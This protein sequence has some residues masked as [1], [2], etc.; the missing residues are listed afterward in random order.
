MKKLI[1]LFAIIFSSTL[2]AQTANLKT[3]RNA[4]KY[5]TE[6]TENFPNFTYQSPDNEN[7][8][9]IRETFNLDSITGNGDEMSK[10]LNLMHWVHNSVRHNGNNSANCE[11]DAID[12]YNYY[13][14]TGKGINCRNLATMLNECYLAMGIPS[15][16]IT[17][18]PKDSTDRDCH[19][20]NSVY[21]KTLNKW[22]WIDPTFNAYIKDESGNFLGI[23]EVRE[24]LIDGRPV[25]LNQDA[26]WNNKNKQT[27]ENYLDKYMAKNLYWLQCTVNSKFNVESRN[28][29]TEEIYVSLVPSDFKPFRHALDVVTTDPNYFWQAPN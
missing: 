24:R 29:K 8:K 20:I 3:L 12:L 25:V 11:L 7:L 23:E 2:F 15:R 22:I 16:F 13:K 10:I 27:K 19:V 6:N 28:R 14:T 5:Q 26:N 17:C 18:L 4:G 9:N 21:S 1:F